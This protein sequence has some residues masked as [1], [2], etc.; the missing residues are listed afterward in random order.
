MIPSLFDCA[1]PP[2]SLGRADLARPA[3]IRFAAPLCFLLAGLAG[4]ATAQDPP[5]TNHDVTV[6]AEVL[7]NR[8]FTPDPLVAED[9]EVVATGGVVRRVRL[10]DVSL[11]RP[12]STGG[13]RWLVYVDQPLSS[14]GT[15]RRAMDS[16]GEVTSG[17][18]GLGDVEI[19]SASAD[20]APDEV[21]RTGDPLISAERFSRMALTERGQDSIRTIRERALEAWIESGIGSEPR[22]A[23]DRA[24]IVIA[25]VEE[26]TD[27]VRE[28]LRQ[29]VGYLG[30]LPIEP[31]RPRVVLPVL[32]GFDLDPVDYWATVLDDTGLRLLRESRAGRPSLSDEVT[33]LSRALAASGWIVMPLV[34]ERPRGP[35]GAEFTGVQSAD[36]ERNEVLPG[37][38]VRPGQIFGKDD[39]DDEAEAESVTVE[40]LDPLAP[41]E[42]LAEASGGEVLITDAGLRGAVDRFADRIAV[43]W[44]SPVAFEDDV[45]EVLVRSTRPGWQ[46]TAR[47]W[48]ARGVPE[49]IS[50]LRL[51]QV[52]GG[53]EDEGDLSLAAVLEVRDAAT[54]AS[55]DTTEETAPT[56]ATL[57]ARLDLGDLEGQEGLESVDLQVTVRSVGLDRSD[58][59]VLLRE[60]VAGQN[61]T[62]GREWRWRRD[63]ELPPDATAVAVLIEELDS[64]RWGGR[65]AAVVRADTSLGGDFLPSPTVVEIRRPEQ[66]VLR[67]RVRFD[68]DVWDSRVEQVS[69]L[70]DD[71][72]VAVEKQPP[73]SARLDV[74]RTPRRQELTV[75]AFDVNGQEIGRDSAILNGGEA[76]LGV[77][78]V[79][80]TDAR[81]VGTV[82]VA[83]EVSVPVERELDRVLFFWNNEQ[84]ATLYSPPFRQPIFV[85]ENQKVGY[86]RVVALLDDGSLAEDVLFLNGPSAGE[87]VNVDLVELFVVVEDKEGRPV[88]GLAESDF[89]VVEDGQVQDIATFDDAADL[90]LTLG[91]AIDSSASMF[92]KLPQVQ[93]AASNFLRRTFSDHDR[94]FVVDFDSQPRLARGTTSD[95]DRLVGAIWNLEASGRTAMWES[96]VYSLVQLQG[97]RG[98]KALIVFSDGADEDEQFPFRSALRISREMG[99]P[100]YLILMKKEPEE[101]AA[102]GLLRRSFT[103][104]V[105][106]L[107]EATGGRVFYSKEY[108]SLDQI[109]DQIEEDLRSQYLLAYY[110]KDGEE[111]RGWRNVDVEVGVDGLK[112]R[113]LSGYQQ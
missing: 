48:I 67:G 79:S 74:G 87:R 81:G 64:G 14:P 83:A 99:A 18:T 59:S 8:G 13:V 19:V 102:L 36:P 111:R 46:V 12:E 17:L 103:S 43:A 39:D 63:V 93:S 97:V 66:A 41:L 105:D 37:V 10:P 6:W 113:T 56:A 88:R 84:V 28:R 69:F 100:I 70:L 106:R 68:V 50:A 9:L 80:P 27:L 23:E 34:L 101:N 61:L 38:T 57:D 54:L 30:K 110:P 76:G 75:V 51:D 52:L 82:E 107:V 4:I 1:A 45:R 25:A 72:E 108:S 104:R 94:A 112:P 62:R 44:S 86:V 89:R 78:I 11:R 22:V 5:S 29:W 85:P 16:L 21:L 31:G 35:E 7:D 33:E 53:R 65:R 55:A 26:E 24:G 92:V 71:R 77:Q 20:E 3:W 58:R 95:L 73:W 40:L 91:M 98:R 60:V 96:I 49:A 47:S 2:T 32:D 90:P 42:R 15:V 109:Y